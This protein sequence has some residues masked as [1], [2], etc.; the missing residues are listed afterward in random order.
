MESLS[1][2]VVS[3]AK[4]P[5]HNLNEVDLW[6][7]RIEQYFLMNDYSLWEVILNGD[8]PIPTR[9]VDGVIQPIAPTTADVMELVAMIGAFRLMKNQQIMT[10]WHLPPQAHQVLQIMRRMHPNR[11]GEIAELDEDVTLVDVDTA[12]KMDADIQGRMEEDVTAVKEINAAELQDEEMEQ[13][14]AREKQEKEDLERAKVLQ[15]QYDQKQKNIDWNVLKPGKNMIVYLK[16]AGYKIAHFKGMTY[17]QVRPIFE[18]EYNKVQTFL[19]PDRDGEPAKKRGAEETLLQESFKKQRAKV[20]ASGSHT[21]H[22]TPTDDPKE[23]SDEELRI[24]CK[25]SQ[26]L[27]N[28]D[29]LWRLTKEKFSTT[30]PTEDKGKALLIELKRLYEPNAAEVFWK[31]QRYIERL[32]IDRCCLLLMLSTKLQVDE[33]CEMAKDLVMKIFMESNKPK[34]RRSL[35]TSSKCC[36]LL[37]LS[38]KLQVDEDCEMAKDL[39]MKIFMEANKPKS[40]R[41][42]DTSSK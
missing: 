29:A 35:D 3:T 41:S 23:I 13:A 18:R 9:V 14:A 12:I 34:S 26:W 25:L 30:M 20:E 1:P 42:L 10:S 38:T 32:S 40:R 11:E 39:V 28:L 21:T 5:I 8:S 37:M 6:K 36:L 7:M 27:R 2:H 22:D 16:K 33:D 24:C 4:L 31:L 17:D 15:Q 19:K